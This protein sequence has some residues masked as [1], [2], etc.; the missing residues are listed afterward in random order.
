MM[1]SE[2]ASMRI[3]T[4]Q[5]FIIT[6]YLWHDGVIGEWIPDSSFDRASPRINVSTNQSRFSNL[7]G[8]IAYGHL[9]AI[10]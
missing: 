9:G 2:V 7:L 5:T 8:N 3:L 4:L 1:M 10:A 6:K